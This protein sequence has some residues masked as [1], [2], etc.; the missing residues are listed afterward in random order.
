MGPFFLD[1]PFSVSEPDLFGQP[2]RKRAVDQPG[3]GG[4]GI[5]GFGRIENAVKM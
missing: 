2:C 3:P 5:L 1:N 4:T